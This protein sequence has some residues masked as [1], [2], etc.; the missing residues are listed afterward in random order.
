MPQPMP[1]L[2]TPLLLAPDFK[3]KIWGR[4]DLEPLYPSDELAEGEPVRF[5]GVAE[6][7]WYMGGTGAAVAAW[8]R[9][10]R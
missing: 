8:P 3:E 5:A 7:G 4:E 9:L 10:N 6:Y 1:R 2:D